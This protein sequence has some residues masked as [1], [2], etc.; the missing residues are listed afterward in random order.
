MAKKA[1]TKQAR[2]VAEKSATAEKPATAAE[3]NGAAGSRAARPVARASQGSPAM[4][5]RPVS[6]GDTSPSITARGI[7]RFTVDKKTRAAREA[8]INAV[9]DIITGVPPHDVET[10]S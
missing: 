9:Q 2:S 6:S 3:Q 5:A 10:L 7:E 4:E 1:K 8:K